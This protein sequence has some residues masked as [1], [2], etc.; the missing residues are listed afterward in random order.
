M[1]V[2]DETMVDR[3]D[4]EVRNLRRSSILCDYAYYFRYSHGV[5]MAKMDLIIEVMVLIEFI[6]I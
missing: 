1:R 4:E 5:Y 2:P 6:L 3:E